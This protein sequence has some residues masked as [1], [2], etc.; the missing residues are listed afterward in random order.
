[1]LTLNLLKLTL[2]LKLS[3]LNMLTLKLSFLNK[4]AGV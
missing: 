1:M 3:F 4:K 2:T